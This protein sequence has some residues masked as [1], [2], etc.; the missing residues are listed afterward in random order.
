MR[1]KKR[2]SREPSLA[3]EDSTKFSP[4]TRETMI[5]LTGPTVGILE[6]K[7]ITRGDR[8]LKSGQRLPRPGMRRK[9]SR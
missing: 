1:T 2:A 7:T 5:Y 4:A 3:S 6:L 8:G 9:V